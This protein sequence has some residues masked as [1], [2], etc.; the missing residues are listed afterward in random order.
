MHCNVLVAT[1]SGEVMCILITHAEALFGGTPRV[2]RR[3]SIEYGQKTLEVAAHFFNF[4]KDSFP[5]FRI[6]I[7]P[8]MFAVSVCSI[9]T[10]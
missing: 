8:H 3:T 6:S 4:S 7:L 2:K 10:N 9:R 1:A 5:A